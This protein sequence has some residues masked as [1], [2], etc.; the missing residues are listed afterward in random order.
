MEE[1]ALAAVTAAAT[2]TVAAD[3]QFPGLVAD[4]MGNAEVAA[5]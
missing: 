4:A 2:E 3:Q 1:A 5:V